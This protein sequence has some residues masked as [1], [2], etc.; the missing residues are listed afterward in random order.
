MDGLRAAPW[1]V[2]F[3]GLDEEV[4]GAPARLPGTVV[5]TVQHVPVGIPT[6][7]VINYVPRRSRT[8]V[9]PSYGCL[10]FFMVCLWSV[11]VP[12]KNTS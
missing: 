12:G 5:P 4:V 7:S 10:Y 3:R 6:S 8:T 11:R 2:V 1:P 9:G